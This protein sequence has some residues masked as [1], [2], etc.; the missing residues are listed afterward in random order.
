MVFAYNG[1]IEFYAQY[2]RVNVKIRERGGLRL[3]VVS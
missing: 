3:A 1:C 2:Y